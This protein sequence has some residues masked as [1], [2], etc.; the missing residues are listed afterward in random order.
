M[1]RLHPSTVLEVV[2]VWVGV[3]EHVL[4]EV[5]VVLV[6]SAAVPLEELAMKGSGLKELL[7]RPHHIP[8]A[9]HIARTM[10]HYTPDTRDTH[11]TKRHTQ[12]NTHV[13]RS[14]RGFPAVGVV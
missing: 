9:R 12:T 7:G 3:A 4:G 6:E 5:L 8:D 14:L 10:T 11:D 1:D 2:L 13:L